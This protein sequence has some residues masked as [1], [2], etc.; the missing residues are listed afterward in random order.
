VLAAGRR[1]GERPV[2]L[3]ALGLA[4]ILL[5][6]LPFTRIGG[7]L[8][9]DEG[10]AVIQART[11]DRDGSWIVHQPLARVD[12][13]DRADPL[14]YV[15]AGPKGRAAYAK[16]PLY[17]LLLL[18]AYR[19][20]GTSGF[21]L[22]SVAGTVLAA[23]GAAALS[24]VLGARRRLSLWVA[25]V[26]TPL[27]FYAF[28]IQA[29]SLGAAAAVGAA[30]VA[31]SA[32]RR[33]TAWRLALL[34]ALAALATALRSEAAFFAGGIALAAVVVGWRSQRRA[35]IAVAATAIVAP[36]VVRLAEREFL[37]RVLGSGAGGVGTPGR[38]GGLTGPVEGFYSTW[39]SPTN[40]G[41]FRLGVF[42]VIAL[43]LVAAAALIARRPGR[44]PV[45]LA[46]LGG[47]AVG[48]LVWFLRAPAVPVEGLAIV[49]PAGWAALWAI[50]R[51]DVRASVSRFSAVALVV[52][53]I[54][55]LLTQY[56]GGGGPE[57]G[58][59]FFVVGLA[60]ATPMAVVVLERVRARAL[61]EPTAS[62]AVVVLAV[63]ITVV[64]AW[65]G[66]RTLRQTHANSKD[67]LAVVEKGGRA[68]RAP[69]GP[70]GDTRP[71]VVTTVPLLPQLLWEGYDRLQ[72][73]APNDRDLAMYGERLAAAGADRLV[74]VSGNATRDVASLAPWYREVA[75][76]QQAPGRVPPY[77]VVVMARR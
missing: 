48:Y 66:V 62:R 35:A 24:G 14:P 55:V 28:V 30:L 13:Q 17:P 59:R 47:A 11:L 71:V 77:P 37:V 72:W 42:L 9:S 39:L 61:P 38:R 52:F 22:L 15:E 20:A 27:F 7:S 25:G 73:L 40:Q 4:A 63:V 23:A 8:I 46:C 21:Y 53:A 64:I 60:V 68:A 29:H 49:F 16:H 54:A 3:H 1:T 36:L 5:L 74:L 41:T 10:A 57:W 19:I 45:V 12:P 75:R 76:P 26:A 58:G 69:F 33:L 18:G 65:G 67:L 43:G 2:W 6:T 32:L 34:F 51:S 70:T 50:E 31:W 44:G 56:P